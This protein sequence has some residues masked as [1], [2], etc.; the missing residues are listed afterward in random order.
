M[1][2]QESARFT[3]EPHSS[4]ALVTRRHLMWSALCASVAAALGPTFSRAQAVQSDL[5]AAARGEDGSKFLTDPNWK[6]VFLSDSQNTTLSALGDA[7]IPATDTPGAKEALVDRYLDLLLSV[8]PAEFQQQFVTA[9]EFVNAES[10]KMFG[11]DFAG[12]SHEDQASLLTPW[13]YPRQA[14]Q[15]IEEEEKSDPG[16]RHFG[17]LKALIATAYYGSEIGHRELGWDETTMNGPYP[18]C[19]DA[20]ADH[21]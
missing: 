17:R 14:S 6:A 18:G 10:Q 4:S 13:A 8:Q 21:P 12:L 3:I 5:T 19:E 15:W 16:Q 7:I 11:K 20:S 1:T 2:I 9:L